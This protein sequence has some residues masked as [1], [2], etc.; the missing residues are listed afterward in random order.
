MDC[1]FTLAASGRYRAFALSTRPRS[2]F[3]TGGAICR[4]GPMPASLRAGDPVKTLRHHA[5]R[6]A[7]APLVADDVVEFHAARVL[8]LLR[9]WGCVSSNHW[10]NEAGKARFLRALSGLLQRCDRR[11]RA[12]GT[13]A[14]RRDRGGHN[15]TPLWPLGQTLLPRPRFFGGAGARLRKKDGQVRSDLSHPVRKDRGAGAIEPTRLCGIVPADGISGRK[16]WE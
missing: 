4:H 5:S 3:L 1:N 12:I 6:P 11:A 7:S 10:A 8:L 14:K 9:I 2:E 16:A 13:G 15:S